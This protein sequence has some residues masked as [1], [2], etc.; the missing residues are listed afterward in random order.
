MLW[1]E[2]WP[3]PFALLQIRV[4]CVSVCANSD[5]DSLQRV[6][7]LRSLNHVRVVALRVTAT[8]MSDVHTAPSP[9]KDIDTT[10]KP[11]LTNSYLCVFVS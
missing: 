11:R 5:G 3:V 6:A 8:H 1:S 9:L 4:E 2:S 7:Y 10:R